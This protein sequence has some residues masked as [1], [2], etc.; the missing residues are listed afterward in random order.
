MTLA[1]EGPMTLPMLLGGIICQQGAWK[2][3]LPCKEPLTIA[4][5]DALHTFLQD[6][7]QSSSITHVFLTSACAVCDWLCLG[8]FRISKCGQTSS[9]KSPSG[10]HRACVPNSPDAGIWANQPLAFVEANFVFCS[11]EA[12]L[13]DQ[14]TLPAQRCSGSHLGAPPSTLL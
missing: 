6:Q 4:M 2:A 11:T 10:K 5:I 8:V 12:T 13:I 3:L 14:R 9:A 7:T 1:N